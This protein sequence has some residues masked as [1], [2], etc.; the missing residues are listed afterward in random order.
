V[1]ALINGKP[2]IL[3]HRGASA[4]APENTLA[5]FAR[6]M[7]EGADGIEF[8]VRLTRDGVPVVI[9]DASLKRTALI[10]RLV[11][12]LTA[13]E[14]QQV[15]VGSWFAAPG[16]TGPGPFAGETLPTLAQVFDLFK[17]NSGV[18]YVE[19]KCSQREGAALAAAVARETRSSGIADRVVV[20]SF[21]LAALAEIKQID[22]GLRTAAL[23]EPQLFRPLAT[24]RRLR[25]VETALR[26]A[27][28]EIALHHTLAGPRT[29]EKAKL[30][31]LEV[32]VWTVDDREWLRRAT[33][34]GI[35]ALICNDPS[36]MLRYQNNH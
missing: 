1:C 9:H 36:L 20:E 24:V 15:D 23:F 12:D 28:D 33:A 21:D 17:S 10:D 35:K 13:A 22:A 4:V 2:L 16:Q 30:A 6:A 18:L 32:V 29:V 3:G 14:L 34:R 31:G 5:A 11:S 27:A 19:L 7:D 25:M 26:V 8:D